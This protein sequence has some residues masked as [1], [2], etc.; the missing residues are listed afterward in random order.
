MMWMM[1]PQ[2]EP[3]DKWALKA[4]ELGYRARSVFKLQ[5]LDERFKII[6]KGYNILDI[7][8]APGSWLQYVEKRMGPQGQAIGLDL[9]P[10]EGL[11]K[12]IQTFVCNIEQLE[13][14]DV[15]LQ[16]A[17]PALFDVVLSDIAPSTSGIKDRDQ[18][19]SIELSTH[20]VEISRK[21]LKK[22]GTLVMKILRGADFDVFLKELKPH[23]REVKVAHAKASRQS[24]REVYVVGIGKKSENRSQ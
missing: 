3:N 15:I 6:K 13:E 14:V 1:T 23:F 11:S 21:W 22:N 9:Q 5:E 17:H 10:I 19:L 2:F 16:S 20:V 4:R 12:A 7:G 18:W 8:A 24:S